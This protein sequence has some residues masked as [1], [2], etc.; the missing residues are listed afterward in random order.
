MTSKDLQLI[1]KLQVIF[2]YAIK[3]NNIHLIKNPKE[4][5]DIL[6]WEQIF[7]SFVEKNITNP[8]GNALKT[9]LVFVAN[10]N[11][12]SPEEKFRIGKSLIEDLDKEITQFG[13]S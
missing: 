1:N 5:Q 11:S 4:K 3:L 10:R 9:F 6:N 8:Q 12:Y 7:Q 13:N 2:K